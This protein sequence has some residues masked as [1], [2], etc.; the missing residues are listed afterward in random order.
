MIIKYVKSHMKTRKVSSFLV[1]INLNAICTNVKAPQLV[2]LVI[3]F[4]VVGKG[5]KVMK[6]LL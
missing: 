6:V 3:N 4:Q 1:Q 5:R 2:I